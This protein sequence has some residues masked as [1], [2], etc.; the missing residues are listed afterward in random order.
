ML[1]A[2]VL[3]LG[4]QTHKGDGVSGRRVG[5]VTALIEDDVLCGDGDN[6]ILLGEG[7]VNRKLEIHIREHRTVLLEVD[8][9]GI[10]GCQ[11]GIA[12]CISG[13]SDGVRAYD[14]LL[15]RRF[16]GLGGSLYRYLD[17]VLVLGNSIVVLGLDIVLGEHLDGSSAVVNGDAVVVLEAVDERLSQ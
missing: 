9:E 16:S 4:G 7:E 5:S 11:S 12:L 6:L 10:T 2:G 8:D 13:L 1:V 15:R 3:V 14:V 17:S